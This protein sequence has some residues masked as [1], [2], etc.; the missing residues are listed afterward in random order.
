VKGKEISRKG[1]KPQKAE[2][3]LSDT[4][5]QLKDKAGWKPAVRI[6]GFQPALIKSCY[7]LRKGYDSFKNSC[8]KAGR[9]TIFS[10]VMNEL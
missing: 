2:R 1:A 9:R 8:P 3:A 5:I 4:K 7:S 10:P 6:A